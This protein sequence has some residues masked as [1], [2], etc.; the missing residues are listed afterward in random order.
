MHR[1]TDGYMKQWTERAFSDPY[2]SSGNGYLPSDVS[3]GLG[4]TEE[5]MLYEENSDTDPWNKQFT[6]NE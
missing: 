1:I 6:A 4:S 3:Q 5:P 2:D